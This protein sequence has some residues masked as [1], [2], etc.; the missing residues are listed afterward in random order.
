MAATAGA[1]AIS[2][3]VALSLGT[4]A[5]AGE[6]QP[7]QKA[8]VE[9]R[10]ATA[11]DANA[12][13]GWTLRW[14]PDPVKDGLEAFEGV[15][16][17]RAGSDPG[18]KH[19]YVED[20]AY[21]FDM[22]LEERDSSPDRQRNEVKG[23]SAEGRDLTISEGET[24]RFTDSL[25]IPSS[26][27]ATS[28]FTHIMQFKMPGAGSGPIIVMSLRQHDGKPT[29]ELN[30]ALSGRIVGRTDLAPLQNK[31]IGFDL[32]ITFGDGDGKIRWVVTDGS[33]TV[34]DASASGLDTW[35][36]ERARPKWGIYRSL[37]D[38]AHLKNTYL[39][40]KDLKAYQQT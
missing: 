18:V 16:D 33:S 14:S 24:W 21:R 19:I 3:L 12:D 26:L 28:S 27:E 9:V 5:M 7:D 29:I 40:V 11:S 34:A 30:S 20:G 17:D 8:K 10:A 25:F 4:N 36:G 39:L 37:K 31:W 38:S 6:A 2:A 1:A 22:P 15:E 13:A 32:Q 23:M 35:L